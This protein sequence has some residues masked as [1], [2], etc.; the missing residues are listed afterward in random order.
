MGVR[1]RGDRARKP[2][3]PL[4]E[5]VEGLDATEGIRRPWFERKA[6]EVSL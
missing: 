1:N 6:Q 4:G 3:E 2:G 5:E